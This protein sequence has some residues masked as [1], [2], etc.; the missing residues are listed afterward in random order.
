MHTLNVRPRPA[1]ELP[2]PLL[3][4][5]QLLAR[6]CRQG[7]PIAGTHRLDPL[8]V[9]CWRMRISASPMPLF[10][11]LTPHHSGALPRRHVYRLHST[12]PPFACCRQMICKA[13]RCVRLEPPL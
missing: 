5:S 7:N 8:K 3:A 12:L 1:P 9:L 13:K 11:R 4:H 6:A 2:L 10:R